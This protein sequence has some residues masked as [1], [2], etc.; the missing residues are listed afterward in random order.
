MAF[1]NSQ[2]FN[3]WQSPPF[4]EFSV[5]PVAASLGE[6]TYSSFP[7]PTINFEGSAEESSFSISTSVK[8]PKAS[9]W[10][11][12]KVD[13][14]PDN[15]AI[16]SAYVNS[17]SNHQHLSGKLKDEAVSPKT[18]INLPCDVSFSQGSLGIQNHPSNSSRHG[19]RWART[20]C[21]RFPQAQDHIMAERKR[22]EKL[23]QRFIALSA[24]IPGLKKMDKAS[25]LGDAIKYLKQLQERVEV[26]E[27]QTGQR[28]V[29]TIVSVKK[30]RVCDDGDLSNGSFDEPLPE[31]EVRVSGVDVLVRVHCRKTDRALEMIVAEVQK[32]HL[33]ITNSSFITFGPCLLDI[34]LVAKMNPEFNLSAQDLVKNL[35]S[36]FNPSL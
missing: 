11:P 15:Q 3:L 4:D 17:D 25:V 23:S 20:S 34:T 33:N 27:D 14:L 28:A 21:G 30:L 1:D 16:T 31:I 18:V 2:I 26:L 12:V 13:V 9:Q 8:H 22:R 19:G 35:R 6:H 10:T 5:L 7:Q 29:E 32:L 36:A 24:L